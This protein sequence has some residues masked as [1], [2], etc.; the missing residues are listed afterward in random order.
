MRAVIQRV[1]QA[2]VSVDGQVVAHIS[3]GL[4]VLLGVENSDTAD[5]LSFMKRK[6]VNLRVFDDAAGRMNLAVRDVGASILL[7][8]QFTLHGDI[9]RGNRP[10][11]TRAAPAERARELYARLA[12]EIRAEG[13]PVECGVFQAMMKVH[14]INDG[15]V[16]LIVD[17][18]KES[19]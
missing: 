10:D 17:S 19:F 12:D 1:D 2:S 13:I 11:F 9:R 14:L 3:R 8:S 5:D 16:T 7:V 4:M 15:P 6:I 18:K